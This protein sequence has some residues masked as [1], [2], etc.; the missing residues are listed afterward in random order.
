VTV[1]DNEPG[2]TSLHSNVG[3]KLERGDWRVG[4]NGRVRITADTDAFYLEIALEALEDEQVIF[5]RTW[6]ERIERI[7]A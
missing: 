4:A 2:S 1:E 5:E 3:L 6:R 7:Y